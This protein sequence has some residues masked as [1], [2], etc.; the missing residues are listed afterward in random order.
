MTMDCFALLAMTAEGSVALIATSH[1]ALQRHFSRLPKSRDGRSIA[2][3][4]Q[5]RAELQLRRRQWDKTSE[6]P[7][8]HGALHWWALSK[9]VKP[10]FLKRYWRA[11]A[12]FR[13][14]AASMPELRSAMPAPRPAATRWASASPPP[15]PVSWATVTPLSIVRARWNSRTTCAPRSRRS[16]PRSW[17]ARPTNASCRSFR[18]SCANSRISAFRAFC[19][20]TRST[21]PTSASARRSRP[22]SR[23]RGF[24]WCC[25]RFRSGT[26][27]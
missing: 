14:P 26:A 21:A 17:S 6:V 2:S 13:V 7:A 3:P 4:T 19:F 22:C 24:R 11:P 16:M 10:H 23:H 20:S 18:S 8:V 1:V 5:S 15:P 12:P 9:A 27:I 25:G